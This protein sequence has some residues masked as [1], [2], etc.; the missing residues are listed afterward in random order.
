MLVRLDQAGKLGNIGDTIIT[1][2]QF[3][4]CEECYLVPRPYKSGK[5][6]LL[7]LKWLADI[8]P[9]HL[10]TLKEGLADLIVEAF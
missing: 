3:I 6:G 7:K 2:L 1:W 8:C 10:P 4:K 9:Q 5:E